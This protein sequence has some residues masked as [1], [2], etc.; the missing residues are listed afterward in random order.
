MKRVIAVLVCIALLVTS[1]AISVPIMAS[2]SGEGASV[3]YFEDDFS[4]GDLHKWT[5]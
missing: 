3:A 2:G 5:V 4:A 1:M